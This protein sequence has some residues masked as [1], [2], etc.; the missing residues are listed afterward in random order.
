MIKFL[1]MPLPVSD[2]PHIGT[3]IESFLRSYLRQVAWWRV[4]RWMLAYIHRWES[5][6][7]RLYG[8]FM[9][10]VNIRN[11]NSSSWFLRVF[12]LVW[13]KFASLTCKNVFS[14]YL[15]LMSSRF[16]HVSHV[17]CCRTK[18]RIL[19]I[20]QQHCL[21]W[22]PLDRKNT[23]LM[24]NVNVDHDHQTYKLALKIDRQLFFT[25]F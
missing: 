4:V 7:R 1:T 20:H 11:F 13:V 18:V 16:P 9:F 22:N 24:F 5:Q 23:V 6:P 10:I 17:A 8:L 14:F 15:M 12:G 3:R 25:V 21:K 19:R 2:L